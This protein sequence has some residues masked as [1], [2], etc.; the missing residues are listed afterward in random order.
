MIF[1]TLTHL[2]LFFNDLSHHVL[3]YSKVPSIYCVCFDNSHLM[4]FA[5][6][7]LIDISVLFLIMYLEINMLLPIYGKYLCEMVKD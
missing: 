6:L 5:A 1:F 7:V 2:G 3:V 4:F